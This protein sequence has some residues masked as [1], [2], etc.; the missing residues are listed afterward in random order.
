MRFDGGNDVGASGDFFLQGGAGDFSRR[1]NI[2]SRHECND[3][4]GGRRWDDHVF[5]CVASDEFRLPRRYPSR[6]TVACVYP[7][8][9]QAS[10]TLTLAPF[11]KSAPISCG[12]SSMRASW[13][14]LSS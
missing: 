11:W 10:T 5:A 12:P 2:W 14:F 7:A 1:F 6:S 3:A 4:L 9:L 13:P 8:F